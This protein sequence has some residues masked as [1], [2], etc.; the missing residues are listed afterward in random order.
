MSERPRA[1][2]IPRHY[3]AALT[4]CRHRNAVLTCDFANRPDLMPLRR[5]HMLMAHITEGFDRYLIRF[6][7]D[8]IPRLRVASGELPTQNYVLDDLRM[9]TR[10][11]NAVDAYIRLMM[12]TRAASKTESFLFKTPGGPPPPR[13]TWKEI[14]E[15]LGVSAQAAHRKYGAAVRANE[16][17]R[18][19]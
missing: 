7:Q 18:G 8:S 1:C 11:R 13:P 9:A 16:A 3:C 15:A 19:E 12:V 2:P 17:S 10:L 6:V 5:Q 4:F 14:G